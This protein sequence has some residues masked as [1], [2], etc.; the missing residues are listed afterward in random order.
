LDKKNNFKRKLLVLTPSQEWSNFLIKLFEEQCFF[1]YPEDALANN[2]FL[3]T[4][5]FYQE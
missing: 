2:F 1:I 4:F 5:K 3:K